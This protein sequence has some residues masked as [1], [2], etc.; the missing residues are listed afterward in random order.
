MGART[1]IA[2]ALAMF[3]AP[4]FA[5][6]A[7]HVVSASRTDFSPSRIGVRVGDT[8][9]WVND[10]PVA[11]EMAFEG[12]PVGRGRPLSLF[13]KHKPVSVTVTRPGTYPYKCNWHGMHGVIEVLPEQ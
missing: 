7:E 6:A 2:L 12:D 9:T 11:H 8:V 3:W 4:G 5:A 1:A 10:V 13:M